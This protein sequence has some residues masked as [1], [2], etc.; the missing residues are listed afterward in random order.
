MHPLLRSTYFRVTATV[1]ALLV[2]VL[3][4]VDRPE[5]AERR[6][7]ERRAD[8]KTVPTHYYIEAWS[9][10]GL[11]ANIGLAAVLVGITPWAARKVVQ[12][13]GLQPSRNNLTR[14][15]LVVVALAISLAAFQNYPRLDHSLWGDEE[16][17]MKRLIADEVERGD[18]GKLTITDIPWTTTLWGFR[19]TTNHIGY[20]AVARV[21]HDT[22]FTPG[23]GPGDP[24]FSERLIRIP[25][26][27]AGLL[28]IAALAWACAVWGLR[29]GLWLILI[30]YIM[31]PWFVRFGVDARGYGFVLLLV[32]LLLGFLGRATQTGR[33]CWWLAFGFAQFYLF[34]TYFGSVYFLACLNLAAIGLIAF[35]IEKTKPDRW[36]IASRW[37]VANFMS[38]ML[39]IAL[40][41]PCYPQLFEFL[42][43]KPLAGK[44]DGA[45]FVDAAAYLLSGMPWYPWDAANPLCVSWTGAARG[46]G[47]F[48]QVLAVLFF[49]GASVI[50]LRKLSGDARCRWLLIII[51]GAPVLM[52]LHQ[53]LAGIRPYHWYLIGFLPGVCVLLIAG[54]EVMDKRRFTELLFT[55]VVWGGFYFIT[56]EE[57]HT[58]S[59]HPIEPCRES[60]ALTRDITN[61]R[62]PDYDKAVITGA[63]AFYTEG[64]DPG[65]YRFDNADGMKALM[66][67]ADA[68]GKKF[69]VN[70]GHMAWA[71]MH[72]ADIMALLDDPQLFEHTATIPGLFLASTREVYRYKAG[73]LSGL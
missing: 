15:D 65:Q 54:C 69:F 37:F 38:A 17:T 26:Y 7:A 14:L 50:G 23:T 64:Y 73:S 8:G 36:A 63:F 35:D 9:W 41:A 32:P 11:L 61:P 25:V 49:V 53:A 70:F 52:I 46:G 55:I 67:R 24:I 30:F 58:L 62:H 56:S 59:L 28:S 51:L 44:M 5:K 68:E 45:W 4:S 16:Y 27:I 6:I 29:T 13:A 21:F 1:L 22:F 42:A 20:T 66:K 60:V 3:M 71:R 10:Y 40:M 12:D 18:D 48:A 57:R 33:W 43:T 19:K 34:W 39:I 31:H 47:V 2:I 72:H